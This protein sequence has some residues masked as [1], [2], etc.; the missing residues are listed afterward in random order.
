MILVASSVLSL[1]DHDR[2]RSSFS[3]H[4][5]LLLWGFGIGT[6]ITKGTRKIISNISN[7]QICMIIYNILIYNTPSC[8]HNY[9][10]VLRRINHDY[11][12]VL[13]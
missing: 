7:S 6:L 2:H 12:H 10:K 5:K 1:D 13:E 9:L 8:D 11:V 4:L 3:L